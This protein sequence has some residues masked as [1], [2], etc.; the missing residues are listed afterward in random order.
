MRICIISD[1]HVD[2]NPWLWSSIDGYD[3]DLVVFA[4]DASN[5][6]HQTCNFLS[7]LRERYPRVVWVAGNHDYYN[8]GFH[9][10]RLYTPGQP[11]GPHTVAEMVSHYQ[12]WSQEHDIDFLHRSAV[13][14][15]GITFLGATGWHDFVAGAP[16]SQDDQIYAWYNTIRDTVIP[17]QGHN[18]PDHTQPV[19]AGAADVQALCALT[20]QATEPV[21]IVTHH[22]PHRDLCWHKAHDLTWTALHGSFV[23]TRM[24][25]VSSEKIRLWIYGHTHRRGMHTINNQEYLCNARGYPGENSQWRPVLIDIDES[26]GKIS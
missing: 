25:S 19:L 9:E 3:A 4:G 16:V 1:V 23:N 12:K 22:L 17:W 7:Q 24:E 8:L 20:E 13:T 26:T 10:T 11:A 18:A 5:R 14:I 15:Q 6:V 21:I 2:V